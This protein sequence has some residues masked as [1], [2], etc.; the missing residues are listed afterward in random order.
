MSAAKGSP[1]V[2]VFAGHAVAG[3]LPPE[4][5]WSRGQA[6]HARPAACTCEKKPGRHSHAAEAFV[7]GSDVVPGGHGCI[8]VS[9]SQ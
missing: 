5:T 3:A 7:P 1:Y 9:P 4:H 6:T 2:L 8:W